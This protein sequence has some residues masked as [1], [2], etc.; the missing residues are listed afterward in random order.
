[1][2]YAEIVIALNAKKNIL[3][4]SLEH[5]ENEIER[6]NDE[7]NVIRTGIDNI[8]DAINSIEEL[9]AVIGD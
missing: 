9:A 5:I 3:D 7:C 1:M 2:K 4:N 6:L 8:N